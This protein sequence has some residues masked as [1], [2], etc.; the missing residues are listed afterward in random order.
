MVALGILLGVLALLGF[1]HAKRAQVTDTAG[2]NG[3]VIADTTRVTA[4][5]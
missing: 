5:V 4:S 3:H 2:S 1:R